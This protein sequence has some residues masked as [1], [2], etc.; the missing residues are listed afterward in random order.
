[1]ARPGVL[2]RTLVVA[3]IVASALALGIVV[4]AI[5]GVLLLEREVRQSS[6]EASATHS[7][8]YAVTADA[9]TADV[10]YD[11]DSADGSAAS[12]RI[13]TATVPFRRTFLVHGQIDSFEPNTLTLSAFTTRRRGSP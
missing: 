11:T 3:A 4:Y 2:R 10:H 6:D 9:A 13:A 12:E 5:A 7:V 1:M 8:I